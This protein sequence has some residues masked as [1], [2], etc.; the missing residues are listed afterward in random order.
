MNQNTLTIWNELAQKHQDQFMNLDISIIPMIC[1]A[2]AS[3]DTTI[4]AIGCMVPNTYWTT[5]KL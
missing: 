4:L 1:V 2:V 3:A 5:P